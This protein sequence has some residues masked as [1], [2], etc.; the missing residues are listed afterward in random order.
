MYLGERSPHAPARLGGDPTEAEDL[1]F[2]PGKD[3]E[4]LVAQGRN[5]S[6]TG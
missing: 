5:R 2:Y 4:R 6:A 3:R 1:A